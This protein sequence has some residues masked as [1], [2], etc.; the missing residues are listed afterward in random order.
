M[1][2][3]T[4]TPLIPADAQAVLDFWLADGLTDGWP[5]GKAADLWF[6]SSPAFDAQ[7]D[8]QFGSLVRQAVNGGLT[9]WER[10]PL[11]RLALVILLD[12]FTRNVFRGKAEA[13]GGDARA[14]ALVAQALAAGEDEQLPLCGRVFMYM[15]LEH[16]EDLALQE[17]CVRRFQ[18]LADTAPPALKADM[19]DHL[20]YAHRHRDI[21]ARFSRF[22]HR[23]ATLGRESTPEEIAYLKDG[24]R[25]GQ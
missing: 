15:P 17:E 22:P 23:N 9:E 4:S 3:Q 6:R 25:F 14:Q 19:D 24:E 13:F 20:D 7:I 1:S 5:S 8:T 2:S 21:V 12:Q 11:S 16:A 18:H 10:A